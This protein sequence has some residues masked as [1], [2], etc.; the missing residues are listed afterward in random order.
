MFCVINFYK[1]CFT[2]LLVINNFLAIHN[3]TIGTL[4]GGTIIANPV[5][6]RLGTIITLTITPDTHMKLKTGT[7]KCNDVDIIG[8]TFTMPANDVQITAEFEDKPAV[9]ESIAITTMPAKTIY[10]VGDMLDLSGLVI[11]ATDN[12]NTS[13]PAIGYTT[14]PANSSTLDTEGTVSITVSYTKN[15]VTKTTTFN[16]QVVPK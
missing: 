7:L 4:V 12:Y 15:T 11:T 2:Y 1:L 5:K 13:A 3:V 16:V 14:T 9:L 8:T 10:N 6:A